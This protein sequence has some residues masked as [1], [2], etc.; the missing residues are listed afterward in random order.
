MNAEQ[1]DPDYYEFM[2]NEYK[3]RCVEAWRMV[4]ACEEFC[5]ENGLAHGLAYKLSMLRKKLEE[6]KGDSQ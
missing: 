6:E 1:L 5:V 4:Q 3:K 2:M